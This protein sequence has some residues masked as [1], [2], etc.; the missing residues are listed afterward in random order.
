LNKANINH[1]DQES[2][3]LDPASTVAEPRPTEAGN[4]TTGIDPMSDV[5][6]S[7]R[8]RGALFFLWEPAAIHGIGVAD[9]AKLSRHI[10]PGT[11]R[12]IS[13]HVVTRGSCWASVRGEPPMQL[14]CGD[15]LVLPHGDAYKIADTPQLPTTAD[16]EASIEFFT[17]LAA[18]DMPTVIRD[19]SAGVED[20]RLICGFLGCNTHPPNPLMAS[21]PRM[22]RVPAPSDSND[23]LSHLID[24]ALS[25]SGQQR[26]GERCLLMRLSEVMFVEVLRRYLRVSSNP[27]S[28]WLNGLR[29]PVV[30]RALGLMH[31]N[32][33]GG[34]TL[35]SLARACGASRTTLAERFQRLV[36]TPPMQYLTNWRMQIAARLLAE[37]SAKVYSVAIEVGYESEAAFS[38]AFKRVVGSSPS[39]WR[40]KHVNEG[41]R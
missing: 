21:L 18:G 12:V 16:E 29:D 11:D 30:G 40:A 33:A 8:L 28:G 4:K 1:H 15:I 39:A 31:K 25:E 17:A 27:E 32:V 37:Q 26:G 20:N 35:Q 34:W 36:G 7:I 3:K 6:D 22:I 9:G 24:F 38:R 14:H 19:A 13:Y 10:V 41:D 5:L 2:A 23:P